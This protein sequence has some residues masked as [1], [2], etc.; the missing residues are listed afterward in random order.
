VLK[1]LLCEPDFTFILL[2]LEQYESD[3]YYTCI[4]SKLLLKSYCIHQKYF[5]QL[6]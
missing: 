3:K 4:T 2:I 1:P 5:G 6:S